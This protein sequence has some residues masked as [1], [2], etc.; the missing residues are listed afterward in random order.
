M[1]TID[2]REI[3]E[4]VQ[5]FDEVAKATPRQVRAVV[6][7]GAQNVKNDWRKAIRESDFGRRGS[8]GTAR[9]AFFTTPDGTVVP[10]EGVPSRSGGG[11][12]AAKSVTY[13][14]TRSGAGGTTYEAEIGPDRAKSPQARLLNIAHFGGANGGGGNLPDPSEFLKKEAPAFEKWMR[15]AVDGLLR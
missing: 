10:L 4:L 1:T 11:G 6:M 2:T 14:I 8:G 7:K 9:R 15:D 5:R 12:N 3:A 13:D